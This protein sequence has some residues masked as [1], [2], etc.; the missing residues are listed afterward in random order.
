MFVF[1]SDQLL[2]PR[3]VNPQAG[4]NTCPPLHP[5]T[6]SSLPV[7]LPAPCLPWPWFPLY[8]PSRHLYSGF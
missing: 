1:V 3:V 7:Y 6:F 2:G 5:P 4:Y 8:V